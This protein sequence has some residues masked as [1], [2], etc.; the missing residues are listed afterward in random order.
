MTQAK[1]VGFVCVVVIFVLGLGFAVLTFRS[2]D[3]TSTPDTTH[4]SEPA[5]ALGQTRAKD[6]P[7]ASL[8]QEEREQRQQRRTDIMEQFSQM[9][10]EERKQFIARQAVP[11]K[12][13]YSPQQQARLKLQEKWQSM[14]EAEKKD[15]IERMIREREARSRPR[16][17]RVDVN[18]PLDA[19]QIDSKMP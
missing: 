8:T 17:L 16:K 15:L 1:M 9:S 6:E 10:D 3:D 2:T 12:Q 11:K 18:E 4:T 13:P 5:S 7:T 14:T 19:N